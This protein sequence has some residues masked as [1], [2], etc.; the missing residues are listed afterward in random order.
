MKS[1][2]NVYL[3]PSCIGTALINDLVN[4]NNN[5][6]KFWLYRVKDLPEELLKTPGLHF[7]GVDSLMYVLSFGDKQNFE[8]VRLEVFYEAIIGFKN[9]T[10]RFDTNLTP[11]ILDWEVYSCDCT[12]PSEHIKVDSAN[13]KTIG[14]YWRDIP[15]L[16]L[17]NLFN[18]LECQDNEIFQLSSELVKNTLICKAIKRVYN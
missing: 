15:F 5:G 7:E 11:A 18:C 3:N 12:K 1:L 16:E 17:L 4:H 9:I 10:Y 6:T 13:I 2:L 8:V 14:T